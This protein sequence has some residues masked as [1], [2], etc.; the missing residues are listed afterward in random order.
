MQYVVAQ[1]EQGALLRGLFLPSC[2]GCSQPELLQAVA[3]VGAI[4]MP[5]NIYLHS[6]LVKV[7][8]REGCPLLGS[9]T[10]L[11]FSP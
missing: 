8:T 6:A 4:I 10:T 9:S 7:S 1:P 11:P 3:I 5:H 2:S